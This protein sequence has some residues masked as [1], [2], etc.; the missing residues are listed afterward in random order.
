MFPLRWPESPP[1]L[2]AIRFHRLKALRHLLAALLLLLAGVPV[3]MAQDPGLPPTNLGI[4]NMLDG[5]PRS[6]GAELAGNQSTLPGP[7]QPQPWPWLKICSKCYT[8]CTGSA[9]S[10]LTMSKASKS[11]WR[12]SAKASLEKSNPLC[13]LMCAQLTGELRAKALVG[14]CRSTTGT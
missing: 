8:G 13:W 10:H 4:S 6:R 11:T 14:A 9:A 12:T 3:A 1:S 5:A 7:R 2:N